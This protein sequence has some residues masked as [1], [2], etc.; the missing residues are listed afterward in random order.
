M[1]DGASKSAYT[2]QRETFAGTV[3]EAAP[4]FQAQ[5][6]EGAQNQAVM[7][8]SIAI[9]RYLAA[10]RAGIFRVYVVRHHGIYVGYA[11]YY[12]ISPMNSAHIKVAISDKLWID[13]P[14]RAP[15]V[16]MRLVRFVEGQ[17]RS[18]GDISL[19]HTEAPEYSTG[20]GRLL[21]HMGHKPVSHTFAKVL[22]A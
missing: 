17:L 6:E 5:W 7:P 21:A 12:V 20:L 3:D 18:E 2:F 14:H 19:M 4:Y 11:S 9:D 8:L 15:G 13:K 1:F 22:H 10:E 16:A